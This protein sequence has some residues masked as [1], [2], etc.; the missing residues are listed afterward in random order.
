MD[1]AGRVL[2]LLLALERAWRTSKLPYPLCFLS[3]GRV[4]LETDGQLDHSTAS[5]A[6]WVGRYMCTHHKWQPA[7]Q[8]QTFLWSVD[9]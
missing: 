5:I 6:V 2:E 3:G 7:C 9:G 8:N 4:S 1:A